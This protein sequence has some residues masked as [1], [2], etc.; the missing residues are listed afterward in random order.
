MAIII[1]PIPV[2]AGGAILDITPKIIIAI[3]II[4]STINKMFFIGTVLKSLVTLRGLLYLI[5][6]QLLLIQSI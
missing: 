1:K 2:S 4:I 6:I 5:K 3:A